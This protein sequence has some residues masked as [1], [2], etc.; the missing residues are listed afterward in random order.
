MTDS[1]NEVVVA[2]L[3]QLPGSIPP[4]YPPTSLRTKICNFFDNF[5]IYHW[6]DCSGKFECFNYGD[7]VSA[8]EIEDI[9]GSNV[10]IAPTLMNNIPMRNYGNG[11]NIWA[12]VVKIFDLKY[13]ILIY[14]L[15]GPCLLHVRWLICLG[16]CRNSIIVPA[17]LQRFYTII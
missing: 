4:L 7:F 8:R 2:L 10:G 13:L 16:F 12:E 5:F 9:V 1:I 11:N 15:K 3:E 6:H 17:R 14:R